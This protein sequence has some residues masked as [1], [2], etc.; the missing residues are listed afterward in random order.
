ML[1]LSTGGRG[2]CKSEFFQILKSILP[3][4]NATV[5][6]H[7]YMD[8][9]NSLLNSTFCFMDSTKVLDSALKIRPDVTTSPRHPVIKLLGHPI[10]TQSFSHKSLRIISQRSPSHIIS[11]RWFWGSPF[12]SEIITMTRSPPSSV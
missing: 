11:I 10:T 5:R 9:T 6:L 1:E 8:S 7:Y 2:G 12:T 3:L 4:S